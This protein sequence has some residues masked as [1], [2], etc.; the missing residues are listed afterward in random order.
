M[1]DRESS[2]EHRLPIKIDTT[3]NGEF[4]PVALAPHTQKANQLAKRW[5]GE[6]AAR[7]GSSRRAFLLSTCAAATT[8]LAHN[9]ANAAVGRSG[10]YFDVAE[11]A[12]VDPEL[13]AKSLE[14]KEFIFDVQGHFVNP[15]GA[16]LDDVPET[17]KPLGSMPNASCRGTPDVDRE[18]LNCF[19]GQQF[20][21]DVF[22]DSD[23]DMAVL[24]FV[25]STE[26]GSPL[27]IAEAH[28]V[29]EIVDSMEGM[30]RLM[31]HGRV[32][33]NQDGDVERMDELAERW[34]IVAWKCYTQW[35]PPPKRQGFALDDEASGIPFIEKARALGIKNICVHKGL[36][37]GQRS[38]EHSLSRDIGVVAKR[39][40][41][42]NF[43]VYHSGFETTT[44]EEAFAPGA[45]KSGVDSL[46]QSMLD[47]EVPLNSNV[48][49]ELGSTWRFLMRDPEQAAHALGKLFKYVGENNVL[50]GTDSI[51]YGSPQDQIQAFRSFQISEELREK[52]GYPEIT[53]ELRAKVFGLNAT[54]PYGIGADE[55]LQRAQ[56]D[57]LTRAKHA[58]LEEPSP[59]FATYGPKTRR[60][61]L[62]LQSMTWDQ[63]W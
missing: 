26:E 32:N 9:R 29:R 33:P 45:G 38:Y 25:P 48:Y 47:N 22:L 39:Y 35:G 11:N 40:P 19:S 41:D 7:R 54:V 51:W 59:H 20:I 3:S 57:V 23:T 31:L 2:I 13:A 34:K 42:V 55:V 52:H 63:H 60:Q 21:K 14:G 49:A 4:M 18:Y 5:V 50:W 53:P 28:A 44:T 12:A 24:S 17:A 62:K 43:L 36:P 30:Q 37:F 27:T 56:G 58:Y 16:W 8:L 10:G 6:N 1:S 61:F 46:V 15:T